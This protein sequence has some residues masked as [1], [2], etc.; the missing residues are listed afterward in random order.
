MKKIN[1]SRCI[2]LFVK[3]PVLG[4]VKTRLARDYG[5]KAALVFHKAFA[6]DIL[7]TLGR[8]DLPLRIFYHPENQGDLA[9]EWLGAH[10]PLHAQKGSDLGQRMHHALCRTAAEGFDRLVLIGSDIPE[11]DEQSISRAFSAL[12]THPAVVGPAGDGGYYLIGFQKKAIFPEVFSGIDWG[13]ASVLEKTLG[14][15]RRNGMNPAI[16]ATLKDIDTRCD[17]EDLAARLKKGD[18]AGLR[19]QHTRAA[20]MQMKI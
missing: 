19:L 6:A 14:R 13:T 16:A 11:I 12:K 2:I 8:M 3:A 18:D 20:I 9:K 5:D 4:A 17:L 1:P 15:F 10:A 7:D